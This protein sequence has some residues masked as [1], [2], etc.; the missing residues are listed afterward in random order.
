MKGI[1]VHRASIR[2]ILIGIY[3]LTMIIALVLGLGIYEV[4]TARERSAQVYLEELETAKTCEDFLKLIISNVDNHSL[5]L[6]INPKV[7]TAFEKNRLESNLKVGNILNEWILH[8][9]EIRSVHMM[10]LDG[11][12]L[13]ASNVTAD[14]QKKGGFINQFSASSLKRINDKT[15]QMFVGIGSDYVGTEYKKTLYMARRVNGPDQITTLGYIFYFFD[16][17][18]LQDKLSGFLERNH[19]ELLL[20][21]QEGHTLNL[22][23]SNE[24]EETYE[25]YV[26]NQLEEHEKKSWESPYSHAEINSSAL[27]LRLLGNY[28][29][30]PK[31]NNLTH[32]MIAFC[33]IN[34]IFLAILTVAVRKIVLTPLEEISNVA[35]RISEEG[36]LSARFEVSSTYREGSIIAE[37]LNEMLGKINQLIKDA[38]ERERQ[39]QVL[40]LSVINHQVNPHFLF[41]TLNSVSLLISV[42]DKKTALQLVKGLAKYYRAC[43]TQENSMNTIEQ[44]LAIMREYIHIVELKN[45]DLMRLSV[46]VDQ[47]M[48][49]KK[50]PRMIM[51]TLV[52]NSIKYG[53]K[54]MDE[55]LEVSMHIEA[56]YQNNR[57]IL[58]I[59]DNGKGMEDEI[60]EQILQGVSLKNKSGFGL[61]STIKRISL[62]YQIENVND[63]IKIDS[64]IGEYTSIKFYIPW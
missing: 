22:G 26:E 31:Y 13:S 35:K 1:S 50:V 64:K 9:T 28:T 41:N 10:S 27:G 14:Q 51:Q 2:G 37:T 24:L 20:V 38:K 44:E 32:I 47:D 3:L 43:L 36:T 17:E 6:N 7:T 21:D 48:Y 54:T 55:P 15:G 19:F 16:Y 33:I 12:L 18:V 4:M 53:I 39:K 60:K 34:L 58:M 61:K 45:P 11:K 59:R 63:I 25:K 40:E 8:N 46:E 52:E 56:D 42:E 29:V 5:E 30:E 49:N 57:T 23:D 62:I